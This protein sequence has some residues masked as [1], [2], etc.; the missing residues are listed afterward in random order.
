[1]LASGIA[2]SLATQAAQNKL[3]H[4][5]LLSTHHEKAQVLLEEWIEEFFQYYFLIAEKKSYVKQDYA[6][7]LWIRPS[8]EGQ[9][10]LDDF[11]LLE[12][13]L[14]YDALNLKRRFV[15]ITCSENLT[16]TIVNKMLK[17]LE[18]PHGEITYFLLKNHSIGLLPTLKSRAIELLLR[19]PSDQTPQDLGLRALFK[20][21]HSKDIS[22]SEFLEKFK[23][24]PTW[25]EKILWREIL[26][27]ASEGEWSYLKQQELL[28][29]AQ[30][31]PLSQTFHQA[32]NTRLLWAYEFLQRP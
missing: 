30:R 14:K 23:N 7:I 9:Y 20:Q 25:N 19:F 31:I 17:N 24:D 4:C 27:Y 11:S 18:E 6:D 12:N 15:I 21:I 29:V 26:S 5:Y 10:V 1:M 8:G 22:L 32:Q 2:K 13:F 16:L 28:E 3:G